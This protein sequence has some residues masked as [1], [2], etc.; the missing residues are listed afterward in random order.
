VKTQ[1][2]VLLAL[3]FGNAGLFGLRQSLSEQHAALTERASAHSR[4]S[5]DEQASMDRDRA[6]S[7]LVAK[8]RGRLRVARDIGELRDLLLSAEQGLGIARISLD[9]RPD[10]RIPAGFGGSRVETSL[11]GSCNALYQYLERVE[12]MLMPLSPESFTLRGDGSR[13]TLAT[14]WAARWPLDDAASATAEAGLTES[15]VAQLT[16]WLSRTTPPALER[17]LFAFR[18]ADAPARSDTIVEAPTAPLPT[19]PL[20]TPND[21]PERPTLTGFILARAEL[22][23]DV[24]RRVIAALRYAGEVRLM[25]VGDT[26]GTYRVE[27]M[28]ARDSVTLM[29]TETGERIRLTLE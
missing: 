1:G 22:E 6:L 16:S 19:P 15:Q 29:H 25:I 18:S 24:R 12:A 11:Q 14:Q 9:F 20:P 13:V 21:E 8:A 10:E 26:I 4:E 5:S 27:S 7:A 3:L 28:V 23:P 2:L 17:D